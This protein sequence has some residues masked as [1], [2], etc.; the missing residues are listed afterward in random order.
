MELKIHYFFIIN[1]SNIFKYLLNHLPKKTI[2]IKTLKSFKNK[3]KNKRKI[4]Y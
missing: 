2:I 4:Q 3:K 1:F